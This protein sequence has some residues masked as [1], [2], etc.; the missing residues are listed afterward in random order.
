[1]HALLEK[2]LHNQRK[3]FKCKYVE[4]RPHRYSGF[5]QL[6]TNIFSQKCHIRLKY[7]KN[8]PTSKRRQNSHIYINILFSITLDYSND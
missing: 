5:H 8:V 2:L 3:T 1:M 6:G 7:G 4:G